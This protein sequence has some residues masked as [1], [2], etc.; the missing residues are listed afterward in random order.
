MIDYLSYIDVA[1]VVVAT[2]AALLN[3]AC[4]SGCQLTCYFHAKYIFVTATRA[5]SAI[6]LSFDNL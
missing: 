2:A 5:Q 6:I 3:S 4:P 1:I